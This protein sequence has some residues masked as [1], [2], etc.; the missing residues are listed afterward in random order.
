MCAPSARFYDVALLNSNDAHSTSRAPV[1][2]S[3]S[4]NLSQN[5]VNSLWGD[6]NFSDLL[7]ALNRV[8]LTVDLHA[9]TLSLFNVMNLL[10]VRLRAPLIEGGLVR[11]EAHPFALRIAVHLGHDERDGDQRAPHHAGALQVHPVAV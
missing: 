4:L 10:A 6:S 7:Q 8:G 11:R 2:A 5:S 3:L 1:F 9:I